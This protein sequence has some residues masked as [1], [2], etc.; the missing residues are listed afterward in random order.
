VNNFR[1]AYN[2]ILEVCG[3]AVSCYYLISV[4]IWVVLRWGVQCKAFA[5]I[6]HLQSNLDIRMWGGPA[7]FKDI[8]RYVS[9]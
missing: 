5:T 9:L 4:Q 1:I 6:L 2:G 8:K 3:V 7:K